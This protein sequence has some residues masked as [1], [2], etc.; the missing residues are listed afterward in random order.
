[1]YRLA[2]V[3]ARLLDAYSLLI[4]VWCVLSWIPRRPGSWVEVASDAIGAL[5]EPYLR[6]FRRFMPPLGGIDFSPVIA[7]LVLE[8][9]ERV[10]LRII[11]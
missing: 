7:I 8:L 3:V 1:M 5:V 11:V 4:V 9:L 2:L 10:V 6:L